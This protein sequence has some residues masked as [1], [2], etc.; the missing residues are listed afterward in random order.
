MC[1]PLWFEGPGGFS[2]Q[3]GDFCV[4]GIADWLTCFSSD[5]SGEHLC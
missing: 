1:V 2:P 3:S 4:D 5:I